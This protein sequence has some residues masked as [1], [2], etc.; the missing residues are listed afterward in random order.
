MKTKLEKN[1]SA[2]LDALTLKQLRALLA[3]ERYGSLTRAA[4]SLHQTVPAIHSQIK[5]LEAAVGQQ[6]L[7]KAA[8]GTGFAPS[9]AGQAILR[10]ARRIEANLSHAVQEIGALSRGHSGRVVLGTVST[11]KYFAPKLV[12]LLRDAAP[13]IE[14][15]LRITN[16]ADTLKAMRRGEYDLVIMGRPPREVMGD[17][18]PL[19]PHPHGIVVPPDHPLAAQDGFDPSLLLK[20]TFL[21][22]EEGS[23]TRLLMER[24]LD[25]LAEGVVPPM[26]MMPSNETIKQAVLAGLG[27]GFLS[28]HTVSEE[29]ASGRLALVRGSGL[30]VMR[31]WYL[32]I[33]RQLGQ[34]PSQ[35]TTRLAAEVEALAGRYLPHLSV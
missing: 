2:R 18:I 1:E 31:H 5:N 9:D 10:A 4:E 27:I 33:T 15:D 22:R 20:E 8:D 7:V 17:A 12:R 16:R 24:F 30:P 26:V 21:C 13:D 25:R 28:M 34:D 3:V 32:V 35:A 6:L 14:V 23:G 29:V 19:G 11:A